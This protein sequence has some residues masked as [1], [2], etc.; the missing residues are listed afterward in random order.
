MSISFIMF[1]YYHKIEFSLKGQNFSVFQSFHIIVFMAQKTIFNRIVKN[2]LDKQ[3]DY[4]EGGNT[5]LDEQ[6]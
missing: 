1:N 5:N 2:I 4:F 3:D 6:S